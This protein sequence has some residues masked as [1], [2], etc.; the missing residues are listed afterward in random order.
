MPR[1]LTERVKCGFGAS[2]D[3]WLWTDVGWMVH[4]YL[5]P[6]R[7]KQQGVF[8]VSMIE[9]AARRFLGGYSSRGRL[10]ALI[11]FQIW[12]ERCGVI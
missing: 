11:V 8:D 2:L 7:I 3:L 6:E 9:T 10:W 12:A 5:G 1:E 4:S